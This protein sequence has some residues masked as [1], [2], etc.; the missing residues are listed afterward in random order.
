M[1]RTLWGSSVHV[2]IYFTFQTHIVIFRI[3]IA[4]T[5]RWGCAIGMAWLN[6]L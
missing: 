4:L 6:S 2:Y 1:V 5:A 3:H